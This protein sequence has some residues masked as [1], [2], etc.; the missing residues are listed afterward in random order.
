MSW[1][2]SPCISSPCHLTGLFEQRFDEN[3]QSSSC[4]DRD[5]RWDEMSDSSYSQMMTGTTAATFPTSS[6]AC[7]IFLIRAGGK[8]ALYFFFLLG[9]I[10]DLTTR[11][12]TGRQ[13]E[14]TIVTLAPS[15]PSSQ[16]ACL[17]S[18]PVHLSIALCPAI[19]SKC[20]FGEYLKETFTRTRGGS[21]VHVSPVL[22]SI[23]REI[24]VL[25]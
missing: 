23:K 1:S 17:P 16:C 21:A 4:C 11:P 3:F 10:N 12:T 19:S 18:S 13:T 22:V 14:G 2:Q 15:T 25:V 20:Q 9:I 8:R 24:R 6:S 5:V 7:M